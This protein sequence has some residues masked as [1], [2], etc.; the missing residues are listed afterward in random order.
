MPAT[1]KEAKKAIEFQELI[2]EMHLAGY[3]L[4]RL[5]RVKYKENPYTFIDVRIFQR[6]YDDEGEDVYYPTK[7]GVQLL[8]TRF[9]RLIGKWTIIPTAFL[10]PRIVDRAFPLLVADEFESAVLQ[11]FKSVE[12]AVRSAAGL[13]PEDIGTSLMR[14]AFDPARGPLADSAVPVAERESLAH[15]MAGAIGFYKNPCSHRDV[16]MDFIH[17]FE[18]L[19]M[20]SHLLK[21]VERLGAIT[22]RDAG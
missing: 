1:S 18:M 12:I 2:G 7:K 16:E 19:M 11:A 5:S 13:K 14:K 15:L 10:H 3:N 20:A 4:V 21:L 17:G 9:Q 8:E 6:G 22:G